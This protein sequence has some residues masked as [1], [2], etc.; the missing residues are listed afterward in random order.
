MHFLKYLGEATRLFFRTPSLWL[1]A[2]LAYSS[3]LADFILST[4]GA[5]V[6]QSLHTILRIL[7]SLAAF[8]FSISSTIGITKVVEARKQN[9]SL[10]AP[11][12]VAFIKKNFVRVVGYYLLLSVFL[13]PMLFL[14]LMMRAFFRNGLDFYSLDPPLLT[15]L[16]PLIFLAIVAFGYLSVFS[17]VLV[18][19]GSAIKNPFG[20]TWKF[21]NQ[22][23]L[24]IF[25]IS[26]FTSGLYQL[27][28]F[29][30]QAITGSEYVIYGI[31]TIS[32]LLIYS[33]AQCTW[34]LVYLDLKDK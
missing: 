22:H 11:E 19:E 31:Q 34:A 1:F 3:R 5:S 16:P 29:G 4:L 2:T 28:A 27:V 25:S 6:P 33:I 20:H 26:L 24:L 17:V 9:S 14:F 8:I 7:F 32:A 18:I 13:S 12:L 10:T 23:L 30:A 21:L 15:V